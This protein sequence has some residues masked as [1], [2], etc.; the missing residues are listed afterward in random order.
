VALHFN[1]RKWRVIR[2]PAKLLPPGR[3]VLPGQLLARSRKSVWGTVYAAAGGSR[4]PVILLHWNGR[5][6][7]RAGGQRPAGSLT[8]PIAPDGHGGLWLAAQRP[9]GT[10]FLA[11]Y[12]RGRWV[13]A[14]VPGRPVTVTALAQV[15]GTRT[16][17][18]AGTGS[19]Q[20]G[21]RGGAVI[22][23]YGS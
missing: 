6:W 20:A 19:P 18:A 5:R 15:P 12:R 1:G 10:S 7:R 22:L 21:S 9:A 14:A 17:W 2:L 8:G 11:H 23:R 16:L 13:Q 3:T 4:G